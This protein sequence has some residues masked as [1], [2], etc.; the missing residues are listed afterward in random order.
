MSGVCDVGVFDCKYPGAPGGLNS[1]GCAPYESPYK[2]MDGSTWL[3]AVAVIVAATMAY[4]IGANDSANSWGTSV[5]SGG[6]CVHATKDSNAHE[7]V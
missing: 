7:T 5:G 2:D 1:P 3:I 4:G 6:E